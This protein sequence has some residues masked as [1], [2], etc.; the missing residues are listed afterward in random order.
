MTHNANPSDATVNNND[1]VA[2]T[3]DD[4]LIDPVCDPKHPHKVEFSDISM[5]AYNIREGI[6]RTPCMVGEITWRN[7][8]YLI[9]FLE[10]P[11][12]FRRSWG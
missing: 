6:V 3:D 5:A 4:D 9:H 12:T 2:R 7:Q 8:V 11:S 1:T 10:V